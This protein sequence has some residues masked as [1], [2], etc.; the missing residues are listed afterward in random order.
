MENKITT[1]GETLAKD[2]TSLNKDIAALKQD[3]ARLAADVKRHAGAHVDAT[4]QLVTEKI[5]MAHEAATARPLLILSAGF[6][7]GFL[8]A[9]RLRR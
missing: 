8:F 3:M 5:Q 9:L 7:F 6:F 1:T 4:R 2:L